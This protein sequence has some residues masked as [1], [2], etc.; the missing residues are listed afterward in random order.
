MGL[1]FLGGAFCFVYFRFLFLFGLVLREK[2]R[3]KEVGGRHGPPFKR[4][5]SKY[6]QEGLFPVATEVVSY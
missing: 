6:P 5:Y 1:V 3:E 2:E 4:D